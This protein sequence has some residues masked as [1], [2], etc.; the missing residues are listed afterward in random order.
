MLI[1]TTILCKS[2]TIATL[3]HLEPLLP[4][5]YIQIV[6]FTP[7]LQRAL[8]YSKT[9]FLY[10]STTTKLLPLAIFIKECYLS[11]RASIQCW[12]VIVSLVP[13]VVCKFMQGHHANQ[14]LQPNRLHYGFRK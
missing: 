2:C 13:I 5:N 12:D 9:M 11:R 10:Y 8:F 4:K 1:F 7:N 3:K 14:Y 6:A